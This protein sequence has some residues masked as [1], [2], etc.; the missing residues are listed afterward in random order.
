MAV[1]TIE[2]SPVIDA[3]FNTVASNEWSSRGRST[4]QVWITIPRMLLP[5]RRSRYLSPT[6][7]SR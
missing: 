1:G 7:S 6:S 5:S 4:G 2:I 3:T